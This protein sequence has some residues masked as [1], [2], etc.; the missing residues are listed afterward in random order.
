[1]NDEPIIQTRGLTRY[2]GSK[3][4]VENLDLSVPREVYLRSWAAMGRAR[5]RR[6][7]C[8]WGW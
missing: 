3:P 6:Y 2:F 4:A 1:M 5:R 7:G 8:C